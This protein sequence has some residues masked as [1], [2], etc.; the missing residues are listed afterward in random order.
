LREHIVLSLLLENVATNEFRT[1]LV[2]VVVAVTVAVAVAVVVVVVVVRITVFLL[3]LFFNK[4]ICRF[5]RV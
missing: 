5:F 2:V 1:F 3:K 4:Y